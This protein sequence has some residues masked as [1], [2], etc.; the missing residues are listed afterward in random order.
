MR[1]LVV[2]TVIVGLFIMAL[3]ARRHRVGAALVSELLA[4]EFGA[5]AVGQQLQKWF[6]ERSMREQ[7]RRDFVGFAIASGVPRT[8]IAERL[9]ASIAAEWRGKG[10]RLGDELAKLV[11]QMIEFD[12]PI[13]AEQA[14]KQQAAKQQL[15][16][17]A[18]KLR[19][20][21]SDG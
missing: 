20:A 4:G 17:F 5:T 2:A 13:S 8:L 7:Q 11:E 15:A 14:L 18:A 1:Y 9:M 19:T 10:A 3:V 16:D 12:R 6:A 21:D